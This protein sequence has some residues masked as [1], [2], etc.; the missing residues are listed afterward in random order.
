MRSTAEAFA[1]GVLGT[2][3]LPPNIFRE[4]KLSVKLLGDIA[5]GKDLM[6]DTK[7]DLLPEVLTSHMV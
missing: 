1:S 4:D 2:T 6:E 7:A 5:A 3:T